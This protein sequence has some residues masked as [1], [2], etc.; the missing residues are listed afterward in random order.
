MCG[1]PREASVKKMSAGKSNQN[2]SRSTG[3]ARLVKRTPA[4]KATIEDLVAANRILY[5]QSVLDGY[6]HV[7]ARHDTN[8]DRFWLSRGMAPGLVTADD[9]MEFDLSGEPVDGQGRPT[10]V[11]RFIHSEIYRRRP[12]VK[13]I[14]HSHSPAVIPFG[15]TSVP[16]KPIFHMSGF[17]GTGV[18]VFEIREIAG[19][20]DMLVR[21]PGLGAALALRLGDK[22]AALMRG[23]G[24]VAVGTS[25]PQAVYRAIYLEVNA[26]LQSEA[27]KLGSINFLTS[28]EAKLAAAGNDMHVSR[29]WALWK[30][31]IAK[32]K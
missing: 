32:E 19:D 10:Y 30:H 15:V 21:N 23:H 4:D 24:S 22:S 26:R 11:E 25:L 2:A 9:I 16:L 14:V 1:A 31:E 18:P 12:D 27:M 17:L 6:G 7:S 13:A 28:G 8:P 3:K 29:P 5:A 20:T